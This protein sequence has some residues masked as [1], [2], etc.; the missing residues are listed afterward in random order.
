MTMHPDTRAPLPHAERLGH[1]IETATHRV[2]II[3]ASPEWPDHDD[4]DERGAMVAAG[5]VVVAAG[6]VIG[7]LGYLVVRWLGAV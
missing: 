7:A 4:Y 1:H 6:A 2:R 3:E 5:L